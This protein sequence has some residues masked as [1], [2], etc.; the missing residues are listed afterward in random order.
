MPTRV[1][2]GHLSITH[3][4]GKINALYICNEGYIH[5]SGITSKSCVNQSSP[6]VDTAIE[7]LL[8]I[9]CNK[10]PSLKN[11]KLEYMGT[12]NDKLYNG[13]NVTYKCDEGYYLVG[14]N[15]R[16]CG[17][18]GSWSGGDPV[19]IKEECAITKLHL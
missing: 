1:A 16:K 11:G 4:D 19:C 15:R 9:S 5:S 14:P 12:R 17:P 7:C 8:A 2:N 18:L 6:F 10:V 13:A 3:E